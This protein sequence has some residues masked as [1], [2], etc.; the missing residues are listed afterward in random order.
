[1]MSRIKER[2]VVIIHGKT[3]GM[4]LLV[5]FVSVIINNLL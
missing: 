2:S 5:Y 3:F 4:I 1:M